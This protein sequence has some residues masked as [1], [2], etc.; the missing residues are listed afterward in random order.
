MDPKVDSLQ[1]LNLLLASGKRLPE[2]KERL[3][4]KDTSTQ[5][6]RL[7]EVVKYKS[8]RVYYSGIDNTNSDLK[9]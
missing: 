1:T 8:K 5:Y 4:I 2:S 9:S 7:N 6:L 3:Y